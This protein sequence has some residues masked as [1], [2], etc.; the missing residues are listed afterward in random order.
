MSIRQVTIIGTGLIGG[1]LALACKK[2]GFTGRIV[3]SDRAPVLERAGQKGAI[4]E[5]IV[6]PADAC[7]GSQLIVLATPVGAII[8]LIARLGAALPP[9]TLLTDGPDSRPGHLGPG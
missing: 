9:K 2:S 4:D 5:G 8:E 3:G 7:R 1:S 6:N